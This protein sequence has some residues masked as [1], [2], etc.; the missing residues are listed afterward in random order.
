MVYRSRSLKMAPFD[1]SHTSCYMLFHNIYGPALYRSQDK[2]RYWVPWP[3]GKWK[4]S[5]GIC[6]AI[7]CTNA[8]DVHTDGR[9]PSDRR[10]TR[11]LPSLCITSRVNNNT[12]PCCLL[13]LWG[14]QLNRTAT[15]HYTSIRLLVH[16][17]LMGGLLHLVQRGG[18]WA[19]CGPAQS[20]HRCTKCNCPP[21]NGQCTNFIFDHVALDTKGSASV[22]YAQL[23]RFQY[24]PFYRHPVTT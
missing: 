16:W 8:T 13:T 21:V 15:D 18:A 2:A 5:F 9:T 12:T 1:R 6:L 7:Q 23:W 4:K 22:C 19:D 11:A 14:P 3:Q 17:P 10:R 20:P 24:V